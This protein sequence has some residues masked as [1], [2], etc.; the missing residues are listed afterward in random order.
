[1]WTAYD[2]RSAAIAEDVYRGVFNPDKIIDG[3][4]TAESLHMA[5]RKLRG[6]KYLTSPVFWAAYI[7]MGA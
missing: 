3:E 5:V 2:R 7:H 4:K 6:D 1:L